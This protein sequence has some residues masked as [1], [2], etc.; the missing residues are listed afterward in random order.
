[1][2][3]TERLFLQRRLATLGK[4]MFFVTMLGVSLRGF[5]DVAT[6]GF[7]ALLRPDFLWNLAGNATF[8]VLW[9][10]CSGP[11]RSLSFVTWL[12]NISLFVACTAYAIMGPYLRQVAI[13]ENWEI[14]AGIL[15]LSQESI[16]QMVLLILTY[17][18]VIRAA[19]VPSTGR[20][21]RWLTG[22]LGIPLV[23]IATHGYT[24]LAQGETLL[25]RAGTT[26]VWWTFTVII[27][28][29]ISEVIY[30]LRRKVDQARR[31]G[32]YTLEEE[33]GQGGM[34][35]VF[36][37][38]H[39]MLR[40]PTA[41]KLLRPELVRAEDLSRF[42][43]EVRLTARLS[44]PNTVTI[45]DYGRTPDGIFYYA[46]E[47]LEG[48]DL[49]L[50]VQATGPQPPARVRHI[51][52]R[53]ADALGEAHDIGLIHRDIKPSNIVLCSR[54]GKLDV[55]KVVD[56]GLVR[57]I[58]GQAEIELR[59]EGS[60]LGSPLYMSPEVI[61]SKPSL[62]GRSDLYA[63][64]AV[65]YFLLTGVPIFEASSLVGL[66]W[67]QINEPPTPPSDR[68]GR[69]IPSDLEQVLAACLEKDPNDRP[70][71]ASEL[72]DRLASCTQVE[73]WSAED[74]TAWW[75]A[76]GDIVESTRKKVLDSSDRPRSLVR[77]LVAAPPAR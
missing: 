34:G 37:A 12:E 70:Q 35:I 71:S 24:P 18:L 33:L 59:T 46:M 62:D 8:G 44:H 66:L 41:V 16:S 10:I 65:G 29:V 49:E 17:T 4:V 61:E 45:F 68:L 19:V 25:G 73:G 36:R 67:K 31:L 69:P 54:G 42:E 32:Q 43:R 39:A 55:P 30:G 53:V 23:M 77:T 6:L 22:L 40:R 5:Q 3:P 21:T 50:L 52:E 51:L 76:H 74:A 26:A 48:A 9:A 20:R 27:C 64:G 7:V 75:E 47:L 72:R 38:R 28:S 60:M 1:L 15:T 56:F 11:P 2:G 63:L 13:A 57:Q 58:R 14:S